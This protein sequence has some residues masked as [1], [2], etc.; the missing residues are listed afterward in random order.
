MKFPP[1]HKFPPSRAHGL[2]S[3]WQWV[4]LNPF[5]GEQ[6][7][8]FPLPMETCLK[9]LRNTKYQGTGVDRGQDFGRGRLNLAGAGDT[10]IWPGPGI[11]KIRFWL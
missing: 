10:L 8:S 5:P 3:F 4:D 6:D 9:Q 2:A 7:P 11:F 1:A